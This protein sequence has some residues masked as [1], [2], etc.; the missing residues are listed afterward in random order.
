MKNLLTR[1]K[2]ATVL[3]LIIVAIGAI[4]P[5]L[6]LL[7]QGWRL[8]LMLVGAIAAAFSKQLI[9]SASQTVTVLGL[10]AA[11]T[12]AVAPYLNVLPENWRLPLMLAGAIA[13]A[14]GQ[15][16]GLPGTSDLPKVEYDGNKYKTF[17]M[18]MVPVL[19]LSLFTGC[20]QAQGIY[21]VATGIDEGITVKRELAT[22]KVIEPEAEISITRG[23]LD[24]DR[25][26][27]QVTD[28]AQCFEQFTSDIKTGIIKSL[29]T[30][31]VSIDNLNAHGVLH[32]KSEKAKKRF[33][34]AM[35]SLRL[36]AFTVRT[37]LALIPAK[38]PVEG[39][40]APQ[41]TAKEQRDLD[42]LRNWCKRASALF[43]QNEARLKDDLARLGAEDSASQ[44]S[45]Q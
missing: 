44:D 29:D 34:Q 19:C 12:G 37:T 7:P 32:I 27:I 16:L 5:Y 1:S 42:N 28:T 41:L 40:P 3:G 9:N 21:A 17:A 22:D 31:T 6:E 36:S 39:Q 2:V 45:N 20:D 18:L 14:C 8:P 33:E 38:D 25:V 10:V 43:K 13:T 23:L 30:A 24:V 11:A 4:G 15:H 35:T 26:F